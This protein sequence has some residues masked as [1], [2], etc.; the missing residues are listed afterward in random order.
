MGVTIHTSFE[1]AKILGLVLA[2]VGNPARDEALQTSQHVFRVSDDDQELLMRMFT[3]PFRNLTGHRFH[4]HSALER[5]E[6]NACCQSIFSDEASLLEKGCEMAQ[7]L[8]SKSGHPN[9]NSGD[10]CVALLDGIEADGEVMRGVCI[11]KSE[12]VTPFLSIMARDG[13]LEL[14][15]EKGINPEKIDKGCLVLDHFESKGYYVMTF[16]RAG[17]ESRFWV[18]DFLG[19][20]PISDPNLLSQKVAEMAVTAVRDSTGAGED[21][22]PWESNRAAGEALAYLNDKKTFSM[23]EFEEQALRTPEARARFAAEKRR[24]E[25][26]EGVE[27]GDGFNISKSAV[28]KARRLSAAVMKLDSGVDLRVHP[29]ALEAD[30]PVIEHGYDEAREMKFVKVWYHHDRAK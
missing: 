25:E 4:H 6:M 23:A 12:S 9:I 7:R 5:H 26:D 3:K 10:L 13:D 15:T 18:R 1:K 16:D 21:A 19:V 27:F 14:S 30:E 11:L 22:P 20:V 17:S 8:Y 28:T 2:K 24:V 29:K